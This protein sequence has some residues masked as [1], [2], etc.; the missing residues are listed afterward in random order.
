MD[1]IF[2][3]IKLII[4]LGVIYIIYKKII[5][6]LYYKENKQTS[7]TN[8]TNNL[9]NKNQYNMSEDI[10]TIKNILVYFCVL[11]II[12]IMVIL[13]NIYAVTNR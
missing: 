6:P 11:S 10:H 2:D 12:G 5:T 8:Y 13:L 7:K 1:F 9:V 4:V 3:L